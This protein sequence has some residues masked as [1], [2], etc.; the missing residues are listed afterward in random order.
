MSGAH[1]LSLGVEVQI[2]AVLG[3]Y[4]KVNGHHKEGL[5]LALN[6]E[7]NGAVFL[8]RSSSIY[9]YYVFIFFKFWVGLGTRRG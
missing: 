2:P 1:R 3:Q 6:R 9:Y 4:D 5:D 7:A 8:G